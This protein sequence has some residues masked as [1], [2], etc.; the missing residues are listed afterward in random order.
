[1]ADEGIARRLDRIEAILK[2]AFAAQLDEA[3]GKIRQ[4]AVDAEIIDATRDWV[5]TTALQERVARATGKSK[6]TVRDHLP[7]LVSRGILEQGGSEGRPEY[8]SA[9]VI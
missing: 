1:M 5:G 7:E 4:D 2:L 6:R 8:R 9:G 3:R